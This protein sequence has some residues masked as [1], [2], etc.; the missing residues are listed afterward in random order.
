MKSEPALGIGG[1]ISA[2]LYAV[3]VVL[4]AAGFG[5]TDEMTDG[6]NALVLALCA[7]PAIGGWVTRFFVVSPQTAADAV[8]RAKQDTGGGRDVPLINTAGGSYKSAVADAGFSAQ[9]P[10]VNP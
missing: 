1:S 2:V 7:V 4:K 9:P 10:P 6:I 5:V 8:I 3:F